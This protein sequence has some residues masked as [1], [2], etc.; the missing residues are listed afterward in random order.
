MAD[1]YAD[2]GDPDQTQHYAASALLANYPF[3]G[4]PH[5]N[6][7]VVQIKIQRK[8]HFALVGTDDSTTY[9]YEGIS[10]YN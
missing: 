6:E 4:P 10:V 9:W 7:S 1:L 2:S 5:K 3:W 8:K